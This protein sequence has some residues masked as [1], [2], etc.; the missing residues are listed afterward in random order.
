MALQEKYAELIQS[1]TT[2]GVANLAVAEQDGVLHVSGTAKSTADYDALWALYNKIDPSMASGDLMMNIDIKA[3]AGAQL[4]VTTD[5]TNLNI[6]STPTTEGAIVGKAAHEEIVTLVEKTD[7][8]W[9]KI[10]TAN[11]EE[12][13]AYAQYLSPL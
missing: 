6:R 11:G 8:S 5:S 3:D 4:K 10:K 9:W 12:G 13:Y 2:M 7:D 1:A